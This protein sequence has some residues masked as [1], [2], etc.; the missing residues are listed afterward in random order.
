M[1]PTK[2][3][4]SIVDKKLIKKQNKKN[5]EPELISPLVENIKK[6]LEIGDFDINDDDIFLVGDAELDSKGLIHHH[7]TSADDLYEI[8]IPQIITQVFEV[9]LKIDDI[10]R[11]TDEEKNIEY[12]LVNITFA[13]VTINKPTMI[14]YNSGKEEILYPI[15]ATLKE[16]TYKSTL[17]VDVK[18]KVT[19][20]LKNGST[21]IKEDVVPNFKLCKIPIMVKSKWCNTYGLSKESLTQLHED[22]CDPGGYFIIKGV[23]WVIDCVENIL[24]NK[25]R[26]FKNEGYGKEIMRAE[27]I[28]KPGD[29]YLNSDQF[30][31]RWLNDGQITVEIRRDKLKNIYI[32]FYL[33]F[34]IMGW[35][36]DKQIFDNV[37]LGYET[38]TSKNML[39]FLMDGFNAKYVHLDK[40]KFIYNQGE[41]LQYI[42]EEIQGT[43]FAY[44]DINA[45]PENYQKIIQIILEYLDI[46]FLQHIGISTSS[47]EKKLRFL[48]LIIR[49]MFLVKLGNMEPT[50]R[51]SYNSKRI[52]A[53]GTSYAKSFKT[54][55]NASIIQQIK[56]KLLKD[57]RSMSFFQISL[58]ASVKASVY[59]LDFERSLTQAITSGNKAQITVSK[60][61]RT[62][63]LSTSLLSRQNQL[64]VYSLL[65][66][67]TATSSDS[68]KQSERA[69]EM[70][71]VHMSFLGY[72]CVSHSPEGEKTGI[73]KQL[74]IFSFI[75]KASFSEV[76]KDILLDDPDIISID[77]ATHVN[78]E[79]DDLSNVYVNGDWIGCCK[80]ALDIANKY[81]QK[82]RQFEISPEITIVWDNTQEEVYF[83]TDVGRVIR[84]LLIVYNNRRDA[85]VFPAEQRKGGF[86]QGIALTQ[87]HIDLLYAKKIGSDDLLRENIIEYIT[88]EEQENMYLA[89]SFEILR[90]N[91][92]NELMEFTHCDIP[93]AMM[94]LTAL[95]SPF[96]NHNQTPRITFQTSQS[97]QTCGFPTKNWPYRA[98]KA[99][100]LQYHNEMPI[101][102]TISNRYLYPNGSNCIV[103]IQ[104]NGGFNQEDSLIVSKGAVDRGLFNGCK[105]TFYKTELEQREEFANPD[106]TNTT[107]I[108]SACYD[109][110]VNGII[111]KGVIVNKNDAI[112]GKIMRISRNADD[113][114]QYADRSIIYKDDE[115]G[116]VHNVIV[117]RN[118][119]DERFC[120]VVI[121]KIRPVAVGDK[122]SLRH[123][124]QVLTSEGWVELQNLRLDHKVAT[125]THNNTLDYV[126]PSGISSYEYDD[127]MYHLKTQQLE[128]FVTRNH[129]LYVKRR[130][131][132]YYELLRTP[133]VFGKRVQFK[134]WVNNAY[135][136]IPQYHA[137]D[138][139][140]NIKS[141]SM[142]GW[143]KLLG[144][145]I[146]N[147]F[148]YENY[149]KIVLCAQKQRKK[150]FH[151]QLLTELNVEYNMQTQKTYI[152]GIKYKAIYNEL[153]KLN[154]GAL[155][156]R[157][158]DYVWHLSQ[159]QSR[160][161]L[162]S[163]IEG[164]GTINSNG[165]MHY[166]TSSTGLADDVSRL[167]FHCGL[168]ANIVLRSK[169]GSPYNIKQPNGTYK[170]G[171]TNANSYIISILRQTRL[172]P[173]INQGYAKKAEFQ[174]E[175]YVHYKGRVI[176]LEIPDTHQHVYYSRETDL[177]PPAWTGNSSR[178][179]QKGVCGVLLND[180]DLPSTENG[181][182]PSIIVNPHAIPSRMTIGQLFESMVGNYC[183]GKGTQTD[184]T[185][186]KKVDIESVA[187]ELEDL[188]MN[189]YG[190][191]RL[192]NGITGE[193]ID[194]EIFM[195]PTF[196]QR[197]QKFTIDAQY[198]I[199]HGPSDAITNQPL[200]GKGSGGGLKIG[201]M[202]LDVL[203]AHGASRVIAEKF[204]DHSD[205]YTEYVCRCG[206]AAIV[207]VQKGIYKCQY[208]KDNADIVAYPTSWSSKLFMQEMET[209]NV[210]IRRK[211]TP[212]VY[213]I[214]NDKLF[215]E[216][217]KNC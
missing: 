127:E 163:L 189:R 137:K 28:S 190:Y 20:I 94:G 78:I 203:A 98:D 75:T 120:K 134:K 140:G 172:E 49:K 109:K 89:A 6:Q 45:N 61:V 74:A 62:N 84:P 188:G 56:R 208:C 66:Q 164:D 166:Y 23:E 95:T 86:R 104:I 215:E 117:D 76:I 206:K 126:N 133:E 169:S 179:G 114:Y 43:S 11:N 142:D 3:N 9:N 55:F 158:P 27:F 13:N 35:N 81:R 101:V 175:K 12:L 141:Y 17:R 5:I 102:K 72:I 19:A 31:A 106:V 160:I 150:N 87:K 92:N 145:W 85:D 97:K 138:I 136:D 143:L 34:R 96:A 168:A 2:S 167:A 22:P 54:Y 80:N 193:Y 59:G 157:L 131:K 191:H 161:L 123:S 64:N 200:D 199:S 119:D 185:I 53:A 25:V 103:A 60:K 156:K 132:N 162:N 24:F 4:K 37:L 15:M 108:K 83:W 18:I 211:P 125:M 171:L 29:F 82:R 152:S 105:F 7:I 198:S 69:S 186:F 196:Y 153:R 202:E 173:M 52:L 178:A 147:G 67:V 110:L 184:A 41:A 1:S 207:N 194:C 46:H 212:H 68:A 146:A 204:F 10:R 91:K 26:I 39:K 209:M 177:S 154:V 88:A 176:C 214:N 216:I 182:R 116:V 197:L 135:P 36:T 155:N 170:S 112:I 217:K 16:K 32:P 107:D 192:F 183:A 63:R 42:A 174:E 159:R 14:N 213:E 165:Q 65:R 38:S 149:N 118:E 100:F 195:G 71:R 48:C 122:F 51:D 77:K 148:C 93:Q 21:I 47:R 124:S 111:R 115:C 70:R 129:K 130:G 210:G 73:N 139:N 50:D 187:T 201:E 128:M 33:L 113:D 57:F 30:I 180:S 144:I 8:G 44:L 181:M 58:A 40:G 90:N 151:I 79:R 99:S 121:R 205:G